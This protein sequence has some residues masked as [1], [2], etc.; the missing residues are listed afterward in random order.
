MLSAK[1]CGSRS[2]D[3]SLGFILFA[4]CSD[5]LDD[6]QLLTQHLGGVFSQDGRGRI[7]VRE[8]AE[9]QRA[10]DQA[11]VLAAVVLELHSKRSVL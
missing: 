3:I 11:N 7:V 4:L 1:V 6:A 8:A 5:R 2:F 9:P 10:F